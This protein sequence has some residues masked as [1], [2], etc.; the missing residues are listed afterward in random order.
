M[1][2]RIEDISAFHEGRLRTKYYFRLQ[3]AILNASQQV[4]DGLLHV[5][6]YLINKKKCSTLQWII[7][8]CGNYNQNM[9]AVFITIGINLS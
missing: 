3:N 8:I 1:S 4:R 7:Y 9:D 6:Y 5:L 2:H